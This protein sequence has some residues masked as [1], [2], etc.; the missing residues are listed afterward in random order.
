[1]EHLHEVVLT[2][3]INTNKGTYKETFRLEEDESV[4]ELLKRSNQWVREHLP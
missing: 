2:A 1:M 3:T 4:D